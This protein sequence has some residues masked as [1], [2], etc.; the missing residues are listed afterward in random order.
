MKDILKRM[1]AAFCCVCALAVSGMACRKPDGVQSSGSDSSGETF[2]SKWIDGIDPVF[3]ESM[4]Y[5]DEN[6][7]VIQIG[8]T[9][10]LYYTKNQSKYSSETCI[11]VR[12]GTYK[13]GS[14]TYGEPKTCLTVS[15][16]G[17]DSAH[18][19]AADV[20]KGNFSLNGTT[21]SY[22]MA[23]SGNSGKNNKKNASI[24]LAVSNKPDGEWVRAGKDPIVKFNRSD[25]DRVGLL[26]YEGDI[27]PSLI[28]FDE[29][30]KVWMFY[31][32]YETF[33][34][35][36]VVEMDVSDAGNVKIFNKKVLET[37]GIR[38]L[39]ITNPL[40]YG[41][42]F[43]WD[44]E[45][46]EFIAVRECTV[47]VTVEPK[48]SDELQIV[49]SSEKVLT[50][51]KQEWTG[52]EEFVEEW[53]NAIGSKIDSDSTAVY[54]LE[55]MGYQRLFS[56]CIVSDCYGRL[57]EYGKLDIM[58]TSKATSA[59]ERAET[60]ETWKFTGMIHALTVTY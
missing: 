15:E 41:G 10:Y 47:T 32:E 11:A 39:G 31:S 52:R 16:N 18:V 46:G 57:L 19:F 2:E 49:K 37:S 36:Y 60:D 35:N 34:S 33:K 48:V 56:P 1:T 54:D 4:G 29:N 14:W 44:K 58:F 38:D 13:G 8:S 42:D 9:R 27:E 51:H 22:L 12:T 17:W 5:S 21:Y 23:Y 45:S 53:W 7:S 40:L 55:R 24:G 59:D 25:F 3:D 50:E 30:G 6:P 28:S 43:V 20:V 26:E